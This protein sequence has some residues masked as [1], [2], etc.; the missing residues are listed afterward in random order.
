MRNDYD[1]RKHTLLYK[2]GSV[3]LYY[4]FVISCGKNTIV[5]R[6]ELR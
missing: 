1:K 4:F 3:F 5:E 6:E 2:Q